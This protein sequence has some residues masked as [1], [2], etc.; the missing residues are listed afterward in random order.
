[1]DNWVQAN[2]AVEAERREQ[3]ELS[4]AA[5]ERNIYGPTH[6]FINEMVAGTHDINTAWKLMLDAMLREL[7]SFLASKAVRKLFEMYDSQ[8]SGGSGGDSGSWIGTLL[9]GAIGFMIGGP[10]G[11]APGA[12]MGK[13]FGGE[14]ASVPDSGSGGGGVAGAGDQTVIVKVYAD[15]EVIAEKVLSMQRFNERRGI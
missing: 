9:G 6:A 14:L 13:E 5:F 15:S 12:G 8:Y 1:M 11:I 2:N 4:R 10:A 7:A 3:Y